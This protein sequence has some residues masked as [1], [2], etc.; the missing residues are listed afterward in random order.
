[1][2]N[3]RRFLSSFF[4]YGQVLPTHRGAYSPHG[5]PFQP[6]ITEAIRLLSSQPYPR[7]STTLP[8]ILTLSTDDPFSAGAFT[9]TTNG[10]DTFTAPSIY[11]SNT[12]AWIHIFPEGR[13]HQHPQKTMRYFKWGVS[14]LILESEPLPE[15]IPI[16]IDG[17]QEVMHEARGFPRF[18]PRTGKDIKIVFGEK[19]DG[20]KVF[21]ELRTKWR[22][23]VELQRKTLDKKGVKMEWGMGE[24]TE[25]LRHCEEARLLR[26]EVTRR[27]RL[28]VLKVRR[29][30]GHADEDP[31]QGL[32]ETWGQ[33]GDKVTGRMED[34]SW[35]GKT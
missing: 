33:E 5:T 30:L 4:S 17:N 25:G 6:T 24:L 15:I 19:V 34:G 18:V 14:R 10:H 9:Y 23:L 21:G 11:P 26:R 8:P 1:M 31:K 16:F 22:N 3:T 28:E 7:T 35:V 27:V 13:V 32:A 2:T 20:E 29:S 12:H